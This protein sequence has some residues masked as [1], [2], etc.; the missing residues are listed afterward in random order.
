MEQIA[1]LSSL[2]IQ[3]ASEVWGFIGTEQDEAFLYKLKTIRFGEL[4]R[5]I[6]LTKSGWFLLSRINPTAF[7]VLSFIHNISNQV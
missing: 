3:A 1:R 6:V 7:H 5:A 2:L 4:K